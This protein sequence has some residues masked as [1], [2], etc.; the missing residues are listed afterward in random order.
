VRS[1]PTETSKEY[2]YYKNHVIR[3]T[4]TPG[5]FCFIAPGDIVWKSDIKVLRQLIKGKRQDYSTNAVIA[6]Y[7]INRENEAV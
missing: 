1:F 5:S 4:H 7:L 2:F 6:K 3:S